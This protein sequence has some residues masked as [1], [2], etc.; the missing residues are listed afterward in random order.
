MTRPPAWAWAP[1]A[2]ALGILVIPLA[3]LL[4]T[5]SWSQIPELLARPTA[6]DALGLSI[7]TCLASTVVVMLLGIP[8]AHILARSRAWW[9]PWARTL[10]TVP[11]VLPPVVAGMALLVTLG[12]RG[13]IGEKLDAFGLQIGFT[14]I[15][16]VIAQVFVSL[17]FLIVA[18][19]GAIRAS[20]RRLE[21][22]AALLG[23][24]P[25]RTFLHVTLPTVLPAIAS[26]TALAFA[27]SLGEFGATITFAGSLQGV[28]RTVPLE[29]YLLR[30]SDSELS[31]ALAVI[32]LGVAAVVVGI[33]MRLQ[34]RSSHD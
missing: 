8:A 14:T 22:A 7:R 2:L 26:G 25:T 5:V 23:A 20:D 19:E 32:L 21:R 1:F 34:A 27:R 28:T 24:G 12:R 4:A 3:G 16:V 30:E 6:R 31:M 33:S 10:V 11:M 9:T 29:I 17:P 13:L 18:L 15:A